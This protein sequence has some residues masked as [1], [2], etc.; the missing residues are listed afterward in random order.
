[1]R[2]RIDQ[3][4]GQR[5]D[6][7]TDHR[8]GSLGRL[9]PLLVALI[10]LVVTLVG[11]APVAGHALEAAAPARPATTLAQ[12]SPQA[13]DPGRIA[14][15][16]VGSI[17]VHRRVGSGQN[18]A[19]VRGVVVQVTRIAGVDLRTAQVWALYDRYRTDLAAAREHLGDA[20]LSD[21]TGRDGSTT[22]SELPVGLYLVSEVAWPD[23]PAG[24]VPA[25]D[26][27]VPVPLADDNDEWD[28]SVEVY[29]KTTTPAITKSVADGNPGADGQDAPVAGRVLTYT[30]LADIPDRGLRAFGGRC[31]RDGSVDTGD[32]P[33]ASGFTGAG[34]CAEGA[35]YAGV[36]AG[37]AYEIVDDLSTARVP[38]SSPARHTSDYLE[39]AA[40][41]WT[42][43]VTVQLVGSGAP[44]ALTVCAPGQTGQADCDVTLT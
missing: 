12:R 16:A 5:R 1:M 20:V 4:R 31:E 42:G 14:V 17:T 22:V 23:A 34:L 8:P 24:Y 37:A 40:A 25:D 44:T 11:P 30:I 6:H 28:L 9:A 38:G 41:D 3:R 2:R 26:I 33:D 43:R 32:G 15:G 27:L 13:A 35:T 29:P 39:F 10:G 19:P 7:H 21:P 36:G 18:G